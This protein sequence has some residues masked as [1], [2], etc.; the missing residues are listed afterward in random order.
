M[1]ATASSTTAKKP[2]FTKT[3]MW[4]VLERLLIFNQ[5]F[6]EPEYDLKSFLDNHYNNRDL[7]A[8]IQTMGGN[9]NAD[10]KGDVKKL[11]SHLA[12][13]ILKKI[14]PAGEFNLEVVTNIVI[15][16]AYLKADYVYQ[17]LVSPQP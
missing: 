5:Q 8:E 1:I 10:Q 4:L 13:F 7:M 14:T 15:L 2:A 12:K 17:P 3:F 6:R 16:A 11:A 9:L